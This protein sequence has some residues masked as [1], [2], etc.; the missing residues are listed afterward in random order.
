[1]HALT[2]NPFTYVSEHLYIQC[3]LHCISTLNIECI[4]YILFTCII[5]IY[6]CVAM[7]ILL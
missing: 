7:F 4:Y 1:M 3:N 5:Y 2:A 6:N